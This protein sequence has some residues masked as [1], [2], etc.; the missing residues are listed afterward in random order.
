[1]ALPL[2]ALVVV[3]AVAMPTAKRQSELMHLLEHDC[4]SCHGLTRKGGLGS[5]L[6]PEEMRDRSRD[7]L[8]ETI[9]FGRPGTPMPP[10][11]FQITAEE[12]EWLVDVLLQR[13]RQ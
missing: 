2:A 8:V 3:G 5:A 1:L 12:A 10:W 9:L 4:G 13:P 7:V 11:S 6:L